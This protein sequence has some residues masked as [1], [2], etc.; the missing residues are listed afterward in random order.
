MYD[1]QSIIKGTAGTD[2]SSSDLTSDSSS[3]SES[4]SSSSDSSRTHLHRRWKSKR[5]RTGKT[6]RSGLTAKVHRVRL[7]TKELITHA[8]LDWD[9]M[10][11]EIQFK[12]I[13]T[14]C[15]R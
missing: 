10:H 6:I 5:N 1:V 14:I 11:G 7:V 3:D 13:S 8:L 15:G 2:D 12:D 9:Y 4:G